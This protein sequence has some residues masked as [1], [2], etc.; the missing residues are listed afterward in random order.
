MEESRI[1]DRDAKRLVQRNLPARPG[2]PIAVT[3]WFFGG[4]ASE[5]PPLHADVATL[6]G[7]SFG[8]NLARLAAFRTVAA[9][10][11]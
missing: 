5:R 2:S 1:R 7:C 9:D 4:L 10:R 3:T 11:S 6:A 8:A